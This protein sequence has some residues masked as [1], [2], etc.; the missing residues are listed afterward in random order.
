MTSHKM[1]DKLILFFSIPVLG[2][3]S[4][5]DRIF[6]DRTQ[7]WAIFKSVL[8]FSWLKETDAF[9]ASGASAGSKTQLAGGSH[10]E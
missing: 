5:Q 8:E 9:P 1:R 6:C 3:I 2:L 10:C 7:E 4:K